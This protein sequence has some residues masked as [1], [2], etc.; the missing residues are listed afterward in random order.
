M[1]TKRQIFKESSGAK[2]ALKITYACM[3]FLREKRKRKKQQLQGKNLETE[4]CRGK[5]YGLLV[6]HK[7]WEDFEEKEKEKKAKELLNW[8]L[9]RFSVE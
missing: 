2:P 6:S 5:K 3:I 9:F 1:V 8:S 7:K 4:C